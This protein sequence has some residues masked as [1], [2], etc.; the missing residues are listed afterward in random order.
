MSYFADLGQSIVFPLIALWQDFLNV[1]P[2]IIGGLLILIFGY[3]LGEVIE[4]LII[5]GLEKIK[6]NK[7]I[8]KLKI[9]KELEKFD[10]SHFFGVLIKWYIFVV[11]LLPAARLMELTTLTPLLIDLARWVPQFLI[12]VLIVVFGWVAADVLGARIESTKFK[13]KHLISVIVKSFVLLFVLVI[14]L[15]QI[16]INLALI[17]QTY[18]ILLS[19]VAFGSALAFGLGYGLAM[20]D[21][22]KKSIKNIKK[23]L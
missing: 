6:F 13:T 7:F 17:E 21:E 8:H 2:G 20:K 4:I 12:A 18:V 5:K 1:L 9:S 3:L 22:A 23:K 11:F 10:L 19:A 15:D 14:A 16:G